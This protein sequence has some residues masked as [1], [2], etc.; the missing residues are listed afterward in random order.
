MNG[1]CKDC[2]YAKAGFCTLLKVETDSFDTCRWYEP[3]KV[4]CNNS[5]RNSVEN[6]YEH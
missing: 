5:Q 4:E 2:L 3:Q 1:Y 6:P